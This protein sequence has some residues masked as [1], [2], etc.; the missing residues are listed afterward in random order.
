M[1]LST[2]KNNMA[3][4]NTSELSA[5]DPNQQAELAERHDYWYARVKDVAD[6]DGVKT[7]GLERTDPPKAVKILMMLEE[8]ASTREISAACHTNNNTIFRIRARHSEGMQERREE[9]S[10]RFSV[11][12]E[13]A[14]DALA[15]KLNMILED[16]EELKKTPMKDIALTMA[17]SADKAAQADGMPT[18]TIEHRKGASIGDA[19]A[20]ITEARARVAGKIREEAQ[21]AEIIS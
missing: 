16:D 20:A 7:N 11:I 3:T 8:F 15:K 10:R 14:S 1:G 6:T 13:M 19:M 21:E 18:V 17:I 4:Q 2:L 9:F 12:T 5:P